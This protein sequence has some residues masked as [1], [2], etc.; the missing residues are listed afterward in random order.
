MTTRAHLASAASTAHALALEIYRFTARWPEC[1]REGLTLD[2][3]RAGRE[4]S[5]CLNEA[6]PGL[7]GRT[8][9]RTIDQARGRHARLRYLVRVATDLGYRKLSSSSRV[10]DMID[11]LDVDLDVLTWVAHSERDLTD[12]RPR[13][14]P[15][16]QRDGRSA[17]GAV[18]RGS[19]A[20]AEREG[21][22]ERRQ[23][24]SP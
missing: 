23:R 15:P 21:R 3:R 5:S 13:P 22:I 6:S 17:R 16:M 19:G 1:E 9:R 12:A 10:D 4:L 20:I 24:G 2:I 8:R 18:R 11:Q 7:T 14:G